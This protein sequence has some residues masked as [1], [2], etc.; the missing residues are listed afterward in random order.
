MENTYNKAINTTKMSYLLTGKRNR[1]P[2][3]RPQ[4]MNEMKRLEVSTIVKAKTR[5][6]D[7]KQNFKNK[8]PT[9]F[10]QNV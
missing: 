2:G 9:P 10:C 5:M 1:T 3:R 4:Y 7:I 6:L 8:Y